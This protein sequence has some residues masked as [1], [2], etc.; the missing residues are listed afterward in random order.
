VPASF[1]LA[2]SSGGPEDPPLQTGERSGASSDAPVLDGA[3]WQQALASPAFWTFSIGA[4]LYGLVASGIGL[5]NESILAERGFGPDVYYQTLIVTAMTALIGN[6]GGGWLATRMSLTNLLAASLFVLALG[7]AALP[8]ITA[9]AHVM[10]WATAMGLGGGLVMVLFFSVWPRVYGRAHL[11]RIQGAAQAMTVV[12]SAIGPLLL[13]W[14]VDWTGSYAAM[15]NILAAVIGS[16]A[17]VSMM[18]PLP[19]HQLTSSPA[20]QVR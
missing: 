6:F 10:A 1:L 19:D 2:R 20:H 8:H 3:T 9:F 4:A 13:A 5:F 18:T 12:A 16:L 17:F 7:L 14:C 15:F 11:G